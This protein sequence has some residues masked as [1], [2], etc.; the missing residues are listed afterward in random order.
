MTA[1]PARTAKCDY[2][3]C[4]H[5]QVFER[6]WDVAAAMAQLRELGWQVW[7]S[8]E[9]HRPTTYCP[10]HRFCDRLDVHV[11]EMRLGCSRISHARLGWCAGW[12]SPHSHAQEAAGWRLLALAEHSEVS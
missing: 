3:G 2:P 8:P 9:D 12:C 4:D 5:Q 7:D 1:N 11:H 6:G 10:D